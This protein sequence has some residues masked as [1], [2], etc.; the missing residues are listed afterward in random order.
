MASVTKKN[1]KTNLCFNITIRVAS[2]CGGEQFLWF[3]HSVEKGMSIQNLRL[4]FE[5]SAT[6]HLS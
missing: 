4:M 6:M 5:P 1:Q 2:R 3:W